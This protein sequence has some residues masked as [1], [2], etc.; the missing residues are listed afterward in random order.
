MIGRVGNDD[1]GVVLIKDLAS[2]GIDTTG[3]GVD[4][5]SPT[6]IAVIVI[7]DNAEN[8]IVVSPGANMSLTPNHIAT[9]RDLIAGSKVTDRQDAPLVR[10]HQ[11]DQRR[12]RGL[13]R[14]HVRRT[15]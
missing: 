6:G 1:H 4:K 10:S 14:E 15:A 8:T 9:H 3:I 13:L 2:E 5:V 11:R 7:D 12:T